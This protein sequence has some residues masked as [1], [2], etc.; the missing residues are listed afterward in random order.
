MPQQN[1][2]PML[3]AGDIHRGAA[4]QLKLT[5]NGFSWWRAARMGL[6]SENT[7]LFEMKR[8]SEYESAW[9]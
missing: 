8:K 5:I 4:P 7:R 6:P 9:F 1:I 3:R 2:L